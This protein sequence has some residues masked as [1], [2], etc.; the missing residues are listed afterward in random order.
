[1]SS[2]RFLEASIP[3]EDGDKVDFSHGA[4][5]SGVLDASEVYRVVA[6]AACYVY[7]DDGGRGVASGTDCFMPAN[8][9]E[10]FKTTANRNVL[11]VESV[12]PSGGTLYWTKMGE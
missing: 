6:D 8:E 3:S 9:P 7:I 12:G 2:K 4:T 10:Y 11:G 5:T 1:M